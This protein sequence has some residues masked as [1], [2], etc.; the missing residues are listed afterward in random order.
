[1]TCWGNPA[2]QRLFATPQSYKDALPHLA[3]L[4]VDVLTVEGA[5]TDGTELEMIG[6]AIQDKKIAVGVVDHRN[7]QVERPEQV[8]ALIRKALRHIP[9]ERLIVS[10]DWWLWRGGR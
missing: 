2:Q 9:L 3:R 1:H 8:A 6:K 4:D 5:T 7:L 10:P